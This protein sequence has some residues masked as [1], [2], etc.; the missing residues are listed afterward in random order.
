MRYLPCARFGMGPN[1][2]REH[3]SSGILDGFNF[4]ESGKDDHR[5][6]NRNS[7]RNCLLSVPGLRYCYLSLAVVEMPKI[8]SKRV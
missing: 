1:P 8:T 7:F 6:N 3:D 4:I 2:V 5:L